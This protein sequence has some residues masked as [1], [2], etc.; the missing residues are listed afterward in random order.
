MLEGFWRK[1]SVYEIRTFHGGLIPHW[2]K[3]AILRGRVVPTEIFNE[4]IFLKS[5]STINCIEKS[6]QSI[7]IFVVQKELIGLI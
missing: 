3:S 4:H 6:I 1:T 2:Q 7:A 5:K